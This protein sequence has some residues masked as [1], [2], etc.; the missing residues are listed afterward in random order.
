M[1]AA[2]QNTAH[3]VNIKERLDFSCAL[4]D[5][6]GAPDRQRAAH[7]GASGLDGRRACARCIEAATAA[8]CGRATSIVLN[9]PYHGGTHLP[10]I[11]VVM[12][13]FDEDAAGDLLFYRRRARPPRRH[14]RHHARLDAARQHA[15]IEEE[16]VLIDNF[17]LVERAAGLREAEIARAAGVRPVPGAQ[18]RPEPRR[19]P[20]P[21]RRLR[22]AAREELQRMVGAV[23]PRR[24]RRPTWATSRT[25]P[26]QRC[27]ASSTALT[28]GAVRLRDGRRRARSR[29]RSPSTAAPRRPRSTS[30]APARSSPTISTRRR[31]SCRGR[32]ALRVPHPGRRRHPAERRL[33]EA[34]RARSSRRARC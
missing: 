22:S 19:P 12:P 33:P 27:A 7:A 28:D 14:R 9:N 15:R 5:A 16:G 6:D 21:G 2:L 13:V 8:A 3:S 34:A 17:L 25:T 29:S 26:R 23:R 1:G 30:P 4:F 31:R 10:D 24:G 11:T 18:S 32:R 20:G